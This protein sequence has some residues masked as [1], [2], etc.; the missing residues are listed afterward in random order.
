MITTI[1]LSALTISGTQFISNGQPWF[2]AGAIPCCESERWGRLSN[3]D[4][5]ELARNGI[6][7]THSRLGPFWSAEDPPE[8][9]PYLGTPPGLADL[10]QINPV[11]VAWVHDRNKAAAE[12]GIVIEWDLVDSWPRKHP[13]ATPWPNYTCEG[14]LKSPT[15]LEL[16][17]VRKW[18]MEL[19]DCENCIFQISN[20]SFD[21]GGVSPQWELALAY[22]FKLLAPNRLL[23]SNSMEPGILGSF[24]VDY[25]TVHAEIGPADPRMLGYRKPVLVNEVSVTVDPD[26]TISL[27][28]LARLQGTYYAYWRMW[29]DET[30][31]LRTLFLI[32]A[33]RIENSLVFDRR[34]Q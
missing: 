17:W 21:C 32:W 14:K 25:I 33:W 1:L 15:E 20:E 3:E 5:D 24:L 23:G 7:Y 34:D 11:Y 6:N 12:R 10:G 18:A 13:E 22:E 2:L 29:G 16:A 19:K 27:M 31:W 8:R 9:W 26:E 30:N 28:K 4:L